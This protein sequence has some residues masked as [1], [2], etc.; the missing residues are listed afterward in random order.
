[1]KTGPAAE[2]TAAL[3]YT[4][5]IAASPG[6]VWRAFVDSDLTRRY[7]LHEHVSDW[8]PG[9]RWEHIRADGSGVVDIAGTV[10]ES[11]PPRR[12][13]LTWA[14]PAVAADLRRPSRVT[15]MLDDQGPV[16]CL[17]VTHELL[18][19]GSEYYRGMASGWPKVISNLKT[20]LETG[21]TLDLDWGGLKKLGGWQ[22]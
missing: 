5:Y 22:E 12:L 11:E 17:T 21:R 2:P 7:F 4:V 18:E 3:A 8:K 1:V 13:V 9:S 15:L 14:R 16:T 20:L 19:A 10:V 6:Q